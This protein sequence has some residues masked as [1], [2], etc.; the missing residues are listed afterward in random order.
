MFRNSPWYFPIGLMDNIVHPFKVSIIYTDSIPL[1]AVIF[2]LLS[3]VL[4]ENFQYFGLFGIICYAL[5][6]GVGAI[7]VR[8]IGGTT[9]HAI[10]GSV[11]FILS[12]TMMWRMYAHTSLAAH[13]I[14]L[15]TMLVCLKKPGAN[16]KTDILAW[17]GLLCMAV[18]IHV[19]F[20]PMVMFFLFFYLLRN[21]LVSK[22]LKPQLLIA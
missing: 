20:V 22:N 11:F 7:L 13:F 8:K 17:S 5:Q 6:G 14:I 12:T 4:P 1:F 19:Y 2:K 15:L 9:V 18:S 21:Y 3:P 10:L 16:Y